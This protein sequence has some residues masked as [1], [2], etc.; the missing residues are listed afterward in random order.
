MSELSSVE[1]EQ[2]AD[3]TT[4]LPAAERAAPNGFSSNDDD[5]VPHTDSQPHKARTRGDN[6][7]PDG[8]PY[9]TPRRSLLD[10]ALRAL[11]LFG[12][13]LGSFLLLG[14]LVAPTDS[15]DELTSTPPASATPKD[16]WPTMITTLRQCPSDPSTMILGSA[17]RWLTD[18]DAA[19]AQYA[20]TIDAK[21]RRRDAWQQ[22]DKAS[23]SIL[24]PGI[25]YGAPEWDQT[26]AEAA[27]RASTTPTP[28][29]LRTRQSFIQR[30]T[31]LLWPSSAASSSSSSSASQPGVGGRPPLRVRTT[32]RHINEWVR[33]MKAAVPHELTTPHEATSPPLPPSAPLHPFGLS[34]LLNPSSSNSSLD[35]DAELS[36]SPSSSFASSS[37][38]DATALLDQTV[39]YFRDH[40]W[41]TARE[42]GRGPYFEVSAPWYEA[43]LQSDAGVRRRLIFYGIEAILPPKNDTPGALS[44]Y[45]LVIALTA[46]VLHNEVPLQRIYWHMT[47]DMDYSKPLFA[48]AW[49][50]LHV[51]VDEEAVRR[52]QAEGEVIDVEAL[53]RR[54][55]A[56]ANTRQHSHRLAPVWQG[57]EEP[58]PQE[59]SMRL[60]CRIPPELMT[61]NELLDQSPH[62]PLLRIRAVELHVDAKA[63]A[64]QSW[65]L[66]VCYIRTRRSVSALML[67]QPAY[68][69]PSSLSSDLMHQWI[70]YHL[71]M[72]VQQVYIADRFGSLLATLKPYMDRGLADYVRW[73]FLFHLEQAPYQDQP[74]VIHYLQ[75]FARL[76][77]DWVL[78]IDA[79]EYYTPTH[80]YF[81]E[82]T[83]S[84]R[85]APES[86]FEHEAAW[87]EW[88]RQ[89]GQP[90][91]SM[92][93]APDAGHLLLPQVCPSI[94]GE[95]VSLASLY[96][97]HGFGL[98][99][100]P[101]LGL[102][103][104]ARACI[105]KELKERQVLEQH[106]HE[107]V[108]KQATIKSQLQE[109]SEYR[110]Q[111]LKDRLVWS[112]LAPSTS[113]CA[114][115]VL[116]V[117]PTRLHGTDGRLK[118]LYTARFVDNIW[119]HYLVYGNTYQAKLGPVH[120]FQPRFDQG[121]PNSG[122]NH[123][124]KQLL[125]EGTFNRSTARGLSA[126]T[127]LSRA[128][129]TGPQAM[130]DVGTLSG[131]LRSA[132]KECCGKKES[133]VED[134]LGDAVVR[135]GG[136]WEVAKVTPHYPL[137]SEVFTSQYAEH[138]WYLDLPLSILNHIS[139]LFCLSYPRHEIGNC[140]LWRMFGTQI[141]SLNESRDL[142]T[143]AQ[144]EE[145]EPH[146]DA[147]LTLIRSTFR[148]WRLQQTWALQPDQRSYWRPRQ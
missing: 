108:E 15:V 122:A 137:V 42:E 95:V 128:L 133:E 106:W 33:K 117:F 14:A 58:H 35:I 98:P 37:S 132:V 16:F 109:W 125:A 55:L 111:V 84:V 130:E 36:F 124:R 104:D 73:P 7:Y 70:Q 68:G 82:N 115:N 75:Q 4:L 116:D 113:S 53:R 81:T 32:D 23:A 27:P 123:W 112:D 143:P 103:G 107:A 139:H 86:C 69:P 49:C 76:T 61:A 89:R 26:H 120:H 118:M 60:E 148:K 62:G 141:K 20:Y 51:E 34:P 1:E 145:W 21:G 31:A 144:A 24:R 66:P 65:V 74:Y 91:S 63:Y 40:E 5:G 47:S 25:G 126:V 48:S 67:G 41:H 147:T 3:T 10:T 93:F 92:R 80:P 57:Y 28:P 90:P 29:S 11:A 105:E 54:Q 13:I 30:L 110:K 129:C 127:S 114:L 142:Q 44:M 50:S 78:Q 56:L 72:G 87:A 52:R 12:C 102:V 9:T 64:A 45:P 94:M 8:D 83:H 59:H 131:L 146:E 135:S 77:T 71:F 39:G 121:W 119:Q 79:D 97:V 38:S 18:V 96:G 6:R 100:V 101:M 88:G 19:V 2:D 17:S 134:C 136:Q 46:T 85:A 43:E 140:G 22:M 138:G 99:S